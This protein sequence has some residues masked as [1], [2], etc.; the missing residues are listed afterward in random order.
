MVCR[1]MGTDF[2]KGARVR[3]LDTIA[4]AATSVRLRRRAQARA[5]GFLRL[6]GCVRAP[7]SSPSQHIDSDTSWSVWLP[8]S[9]A[10]GLMRGA[11]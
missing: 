3:P 9:A 2:R 11:C 1:S 10:H 5:R 7:S 8:G 4:I 6:G